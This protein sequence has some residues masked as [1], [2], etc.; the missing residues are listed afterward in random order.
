MTVAISNLSGISSLH[1]I[2]TMLIAMEWQDVR[3]RTKDAEK[4]RQ[5]QRMLAE[6]RVLL[7]KLRDVVNGNR[8]FATIG[9][10]VHAIEDAYSTTRERVL[11]DANQAASCLMST[12]SFLGRIEKKDLTFDRREIADAIATIRGLYRYLA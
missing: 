6:A 5:E 2:S 11:F 8:D 4:F 10:I 7:I 1:P 12:Y 3:E 9:K